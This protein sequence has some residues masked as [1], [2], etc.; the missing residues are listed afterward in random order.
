MS[1]STPV[2]PPNQMRSLLFAGLLPVIAFTVI[3]E[4]YGTAWGIAA[5]M[6]FGVGEIIWEWRTH[7]R[8]QALTWGGNA[9]LL[10]LGGLSLLASDG[11]WFKLQPALME[12]VLAIVL[13]ASVYAKKP[14]M[15]VLATRQN[16]H[17]PE[18]VKRAMGGVTFRLGLFLV[19]QAALATWA[20]L[21]WSTSAWA[22][23]KGIG[24]TVSV[25]VYMLIEGLV[26]RWRLRRPPPSSDQR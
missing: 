24:F 22:F 11:I 21:S 25:L 12:M 18:P 14:L 1:N 13:F 20:A 23:L 2:K 8:V 26:L 16:P 3:E 15:V 9:L 10:V 17:L 6:V 4:V 5:G 7:G 19:V